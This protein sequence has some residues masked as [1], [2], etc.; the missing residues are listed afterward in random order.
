LFCPQCLTE[1]RDGFVECADCLVPLAPGL[2]PQSEKESDLDT[3]PLSA[4]LP[5]GMD[6][7]LVTVLDTTDSFA[8]SL[9]RASLEDAGI[10]YL[11]VGEDSRPYPGLGAG[12]RIQVAPEYETEA[13]DLLAPLQ[14]P[15]KGTDAFP[16]E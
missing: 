15:L 11:L 5:P 13:R 16:A 6:P 14:E 3:V 2:P 4:R 1:Y 10:E 7:E 8:L 9:A 12:C